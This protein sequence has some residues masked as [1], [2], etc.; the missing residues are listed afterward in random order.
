VREQAVKVLFQRPA[1]PARASRA[2]RVVAS[3][4]AAAMAGFAPMIASA[5]YL[6]DAAASRVVTVTQAASSEAS[7]TVLSEAIAIKET[8]PKETVRRFGEVYAFSPSFIAVR[9][10]RPTE[11][12]FWNLQPDDHH[13]LMLADPDFNVMMFVDLPPLQK[14]SYV[15]T[16][17]RQGVFNFYCTI[18][19]PEMSG[20]ILVL[21]ADSK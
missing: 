11:I 21:P 9:R 18:H 7:I 1:R 14:T 3:M 15:F 20:Q 10:D 12:S 16:F 2:L 17:H 8:G 5:F 4:L 19:Q 6:P 13:D